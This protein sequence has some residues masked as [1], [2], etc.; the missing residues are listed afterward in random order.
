MKNKILLSL[1]L[2]GF[3][4]SNTFAEDYVTQSDLEDTVSE[5]K[6]EIKTMKQDSEEFQSDYTE[7]ENLVEE[8]ETN[9]L[10]DKFNWS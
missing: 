8:L 9:S 6:E 3:L 5:L 7:L 2:T 1:I 10:K 4:A